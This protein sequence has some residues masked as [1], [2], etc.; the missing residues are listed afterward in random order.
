MLNTQVKVCGIT[1][2]RDAQL[3]MSLG[4][5]YIGLV[6]ADSKRRV[7]PDVAQD[8]RTRVPD[9]LLVGVFMD[10]SLEAVIDISRQSGLNMIQLHGS[11][12]PKYCDALIDRLRLPV[13]KS[14]T[15]SQLDNI[16]RVSDYTR[17][18]YFLFDLDKGVDPATA[19]GTRD[20]L[21][22][23]AASLRGR[24]Y[25]IF[26]AGGLDSENVASAVDRVSPHCIDVASGVEQQPGVKDSAALKQFIKEVKG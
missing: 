19:N 5:D 7:T 2:P 15:S 10:E 16:E 23:E 20:R 11:E 3:S 21:W 4:A 6:F 13:I 24:G 22:E 17:A 14:F 25:R 8:I 1:T 18:S 26:L 9:A 12:S